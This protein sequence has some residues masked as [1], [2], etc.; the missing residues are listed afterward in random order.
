MSFISLYCLILLREL[1]MSCQRHCCLQMAVASCM[2]KFGHACVHYFSS[3]KA[4]L[5]C[6]RF[7]ATN[8]QAAFLHGAQL[9]VMCLLRAQQSLRPSTSNLNRTPIPR[10]ATLYIVKP[11]PALL[12]GLLHMP[13]IDYALGTA[14]TTAKARKLGI[15]WCM[16]SKHCS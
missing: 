13:Q 8:G 3:F 15:K 6:D 5:R 10:C 4:G 16:R 1:L 9:R 14:R 11:V 2:A 12:Q 7:L